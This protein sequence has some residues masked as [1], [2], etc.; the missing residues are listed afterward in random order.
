LILGPTGAGKSTMSA[1]FAVAAAE[2]GEKAAV[3]IFDEVVETYADRAA[4][5]GTEIHKYLE[6]G[7]ISLQQID[8]AE[9]APG[10]V[11]SHGE[12]RR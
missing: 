5:I 7:L 6:D 2:R 10:R 3:F 12:A 9:L 11:R 8:P 1:Q 4:G